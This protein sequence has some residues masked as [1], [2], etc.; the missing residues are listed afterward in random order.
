MKRHHSPVQSLVVASLGLA[1]ITLLTVCFGSGDRGRPVPEDTPN[2]SLQK[3]ILT[4]R[5]RLIGGGQ[6]I[7][8]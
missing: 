7:E 2:P 6:E 8:L 3:A 1:A 5:L 4:T